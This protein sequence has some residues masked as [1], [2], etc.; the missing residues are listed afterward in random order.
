MW[1]RPLD[2]A[3]TR[4]VLQNLSALERRDYWH[5]H[6]DADAK[7]REIHAGSGDVACAAGFDDRT[8]IIGGA[9]E[10]SPTVWQIWM[11]STDEIARVGG[12]RIIRRL[13][14][15]I[16]PEIRRR[17]ATRIQTLSA[18]KSIEVHKLLRLMG[19]MQERVIE[20]YGP[21]KLHVIMFTIP[22]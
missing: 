6:F 15:V 20:N 11:I 1:V 22:V 17:G 16:L 5:E 18:V 7:A 8:A 10:I 13:R 4:Y 3:S 21:E 9:R 19:A 2:E 12:H 14:D